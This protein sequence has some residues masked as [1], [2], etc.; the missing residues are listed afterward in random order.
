MA[1]YHLSEDLLAMYASGGADAQTDAL[2]AAHLTYCPDCRRVVAEY[3]EIAGGLFEKNIQSE[4]IVPACVD[5]I[6]TAT[7][8][9]ASAMNMKV[10]KG[11][12]NN[13][14]PSPLVNYLYEHTGVTDID[15]L[16]WTFYGPGIRRAII[17]GRRDAALVRLIRAEPGARF[18]DHD[19]GS[20][21]LTLVLTGAYRD[22]T[23]RFATGDVQMAPAE[24]SHRPV[25][26]NECVCF[27]FVVSEKP[28]IPKGIAAKIV[29]RIVGK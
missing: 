22:H 7:P 1:Q 8:Q 19:H 28:A 9:N 20:E 4:A 27:A 10:P 23:G 26:E 3:E 18:P 13:I 16:H 14:A 12:L 24:L 11:T 15:G 5:E 2:I 29:Q 6:L 21:E 17:V 25:V